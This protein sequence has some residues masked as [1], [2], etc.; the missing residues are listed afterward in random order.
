MNI[1]VGPPRRWSRVAGLVLSLGRIVGWCVHDDAPVPAKW[2]SHEDGKWEER[3]MEGKSEI[4]ASA[5]QR[6]SGQIE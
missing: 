2:P 1:R 6:M 4:L 3:G 5:T